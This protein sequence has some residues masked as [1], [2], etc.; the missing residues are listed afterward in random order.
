MSVQ[1]IIRETWVKVVVGIVSTAILSGLWWLQAN[2][3]WASDM[4]PIAEAIKALSDESKAQQDEWRCSELEE[5]LADFYDR[6]EAGEVLTQRETDRM[7]RIKDRMSVENL[8]CA[9]FED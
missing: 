6:Q 8:N 2:I 4:E 5:E 9:R 1:T 3:V 7:I